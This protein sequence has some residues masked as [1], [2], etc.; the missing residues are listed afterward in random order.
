MIPFSPPRIHE[1]MIEEVVKTLRS[2]WI[3]TGPKTKEFERQI[4]AYCGVPRALAVNSATAGMELMLRWYGVQQGDEVIIPAYT[5]CATANVVMHTG[6]RPVMVDTSS[7]D[8]N[9]ITENIKKAITS[10]TK[11]IIPV[12]IAGLPCDYDSINLLVKEPEIVELFELNH[13]NQEKLGR[14]LVMSDAAHSFGAKY[15]GRRTGSLTD[16]SVFSFHAVKNLTTAEGGAVIFNLPEPFNNDDLYTEMNIK[17]LHGQS[18]DALAKLKPGA[19]RYDVAEPGYKCNMTDI[20]ASLGLVGLKYYQENLNRRKEI[21]NIYMQEL[22]TEKWFI[23]PV[24]KDDYRETSYHL[25]LTR[26]AGINESRRDFIIEQF[27]ASDVAVNVHFI[28]LPLLTAYKN[29][30]YDINDYPIAYNN[31]SRLISLPVFFDLTDEQA[32]T[33]CNVYKNAVRRIINS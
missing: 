8:L 25:F 21:F 26:I 24:I 9:I 11:V 2:G 30:G 3:S 1:E 14:I 28:P 10:R 29:A 33:V 13:P 4:A 6:A 20:Q 16:I 32:Y 7:H 12:D 17:I 31:Y 22:Q 23:P 27:A 18:K 15:K 19:W 5:Y